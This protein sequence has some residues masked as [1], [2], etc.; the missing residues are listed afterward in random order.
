MNQLSNYLLH[1]LN[2]KNEGQTLLQNVRNVNPNDFSMN[3][4]AL[5]HLILY[6]DNILTDNTNA[7]LLNS[8]I[9]YIT[10]TKRFNDLLIL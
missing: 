5:T 4:G 2:V 1:C 6:G 10:S 8:F 3:E 9:E 7:F